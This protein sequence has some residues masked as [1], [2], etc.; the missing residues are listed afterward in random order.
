[1]EA[2]FIRNIL[3]NSSI[4]DY[5]HRRQCFDALTP[6]N[7]IAEKKK[8]AELTDSKK[9]TKMED[10]GS[11]N[12]AYSN[13]ESR[14]DRDIEPSSKFDHIDTQTLE[15]YDASAEKRSSRL[16]SSQIPEISIEI[17]EDPVF[18]G[19]DEVVDDKNGSSRMDE[20]F[21]AP[22]DVTLKGRHPSSGSG[23]TS[24]R[25]SSTISV[26]SLASSQLS[27]RVNLDATKILCTRSLGLLL[28]F[29][30]GVLMT[31]YSSMIKML[32]EMDSMQVVIMR[33]VLQIVVMLSVALYKR[34]SFVGDGLRATLIFL[35]LV[36]FTGGLRLLFIFT[37]F[38]RLPLGDSTTIIF[39]SPVLVMLF[40]ICILKV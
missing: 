19:Q 5:F 40:S 18:F 16:E 39:S 38:S 29:L 15:G 21:L 22:P 17:E 23:R 37:S 36:A 31:A 8:L 32:D 33:G 14:T 28:A 10:S 6:S 2:N 35:F 11:Y 4:S 34:L 13:H 9:T 27:N 25:L 20:N 26:I 3:Y 1:M 7:Y 24:S 30:S 12:E